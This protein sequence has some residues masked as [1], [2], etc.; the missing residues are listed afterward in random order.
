MDLKRRFLNPSSQVAR[1]LLVSAASCV[2]VQ[3]RDARTSFSVSAT[4]NAVAK[5]QVRSAPTDILV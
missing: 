2:V 4:V 1:V 5:L 3:A